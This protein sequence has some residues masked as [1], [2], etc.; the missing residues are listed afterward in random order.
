MPAI[1]CNVT[2]ESMTMKENNTHGSFLRNYGI[3]EI[4]RNSNVIQYLSVLICCLSEINI[5]LTLKDQVPEQKDNFLASTGLGETGCFSYWNSAEPFIWESYEK[6]R[7][8]PE[9]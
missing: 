3:S 8:L 6:I 1:L 7:H 4:C 5:I 9:Q 2:F